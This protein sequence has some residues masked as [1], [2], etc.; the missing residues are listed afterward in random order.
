M[1]N[2]TKKLYILTDS[3]QTYQ[4][5]IEKL[6]LPDLEITNHRSEAQI[7]LAAPPMLAK[8]FNDFPKVK[9]VQSV[10]AGVDALM[11]NS[12]RQDYTLTNVKGIFGQQISE[13]VLGFCIQHCRHFNTYAHQQSV[14]QWKAHPY[15][16]L[17][18]RS[19]LILGTG[20]IGSYLA[21]TAK[22][23][24]IH[25]IGINSSGIP[26]I[27]SPFDE[28]FHI[29]EIKYAV[30]KANI[31]VN[32]LPN[33]KDTVGI[34]NQDV[35]SDAKELLLFNVGRGSAIDERALLK[36]LDSNTVN[37][38]YLDVFE[39]EP[40]A[41]DHPFWTHSGITVTPH[42][43]AVSFPHQVVEIFAENYA[44]Q[45]K[46]YALQHVIDFSKGY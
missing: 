33:T 12:L 32:T 14:R 31:L 6:N 8:Q 19:M 38:A 28:V 41:A 11:N 43:A 37:H 9:W 45:H 24:G 23:L 15:R 5:L 27:D 21:K 39:Q 35:F 1:D 16:T 13:Y 40:L 26:A 17:S 4:E 34:I 44:K 46:G 36:A 10:Y 2:F 18:E 20:S 42:I 7:L 25:T 29:Q 3:N 30:S 22:A